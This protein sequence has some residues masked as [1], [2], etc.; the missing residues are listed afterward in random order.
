RAGR[1]AQH[2]LVDHR[3]WVRDLVRGTRARPARTG[4]TGL[5]TEHRHRGLDLRLRPR[6]PDVPQT[7]SADLRRPPQGRTRAVQP[8]RL[9]RVLGSVLRIPRLDTGNATPVPHCPFP[10][11]CRSDA[12]ARNTARSSRTAPI[13]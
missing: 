4:S 11:P 13:A 9:L 6:L 3:G 7:D 1:I 8:A 12:P 5:R 2:D 10:G